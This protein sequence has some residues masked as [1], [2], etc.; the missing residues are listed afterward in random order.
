MFLS[1]F[2]LKL[3]RQ[4]GVSVIQRIMGIILAGLAIQFVYEGLTK[5]KVV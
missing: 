1:G 5:L 3:L 2:F 4:T